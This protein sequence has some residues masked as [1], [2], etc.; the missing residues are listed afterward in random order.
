MEYDLEFAR[1]IE[2]SKDEKRACMKTVSYLLN[3][4]KK[5]RT[6]GMLALAQEA[7]RWRAARSSRP[8]ASA[9]SSRNASRAI[10]S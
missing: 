3:L 1:K 4:A 10:L 6:Y 8:T 2:C 7:A 5:A 9:A